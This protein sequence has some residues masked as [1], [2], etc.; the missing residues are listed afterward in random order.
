M[1]RHFFEG[2]LIDVVENADTQHLLDG[3]GCDSNDEQTEQAVLSRCDG[4]WS[5][6]RAWCS[7]WC[8]CCPTPAQSQGYREAGQAAR[9]ARRHRCR[10]AFL[11]GETAD[12]I[13]LERKRKKKTNPEALD[14]LTIVHRGSLVRDAMM[15][16]R[17]TSL[18]MWRRCRAGI[19]YADR[20]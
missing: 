4:R 17:P 6:R 12:T 20:Q 9:E 14:K 3:H 13:Q 19:E 18:S 5:L 8:W 2:K 16:L 1:R 15:L 11:I 10:L 7:A